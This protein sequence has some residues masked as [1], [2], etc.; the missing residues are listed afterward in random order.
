MGGGAQR[1][2]AQDEA[3]TLDGTRGLA[4]TGPPEG[5]ASTPSSANAAARTELLTPTASTSSASERAAARRDE[6]PALVVVDPLTRDAPRA[7]GRVIDSSGLPVADAELFV[8]PSGRSAERIAAAEV[9]AARQP[10]D[11]L[12]GRSGSDGR[13]DLAP[14]AAARSRGA[15]AAPRRLVFVALAPGFAPY[16]Y[17]LP[18]GL[19]DADLGEH[20]LLAGAVIAGRVLTSDG[21][22][23]ESA[24]LW[25]LDAQNR[26]ASVPNASSGE[27]L[28]RSEADGAF[29]FDSLAAGPWRVLVT[30]REHP[31]AVFTGAAAG[32]R[33]EPLQRDFVLAPGA[34]IEGSVRGD[35]AAFGALEVRVVPI[36]FEAVGHGPGVTTGTLRGAGARPVPIA[37][38]GTFVVRGLMAGVRYRVA[39]FERSDGATT[40]ARSE[41]VEVTSG[42]RAVTLT[43]LHETAVL[44]RLSDRASGASIERFEAFVLDGENSVRP[45]RVF[46][47]SPRASIDANDPREGGQPREGPAGPRAQAQGFEF[48]VW[49]A[50]AGRTLALVILG[51]GY[52]PL[53]RAGIRPSRG[54][55]LDLGELTLE[56]AVRLVVRV[57][58]EASGAPLAGVDVRLVGTGAGPE[59]GLV[60][61]VLVAARSGAAPW[62]VARTDADGRAELGGASGAGAEVELRG[63]AFAGGESRG[64]RVHTVTPGELQANEVVLR[65]VVG[66]R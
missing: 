52:A 35:R 13:F 58:D 32:T 41:A 16:E 11:V 30:S 62:L 37:P 21:I 15:W 59:A 36:Q 2:G 8:L 57:V 56:P 53:V 12:V 6:T 29:V 47:I 5:F 40:R 54:Q 44:F 46:E 28:G 61:A 33:A 31:D 65:V 27:L 23:V 42:A 49:P 51:P 66:A 9:I 10:D 60:R 1:G 22:P 43:L 45:V 63:A 50:E 25:R 64:P 55:R 34:V 18:A 38:D 4:P 17:T 48:A 3:T 39:A 7:R 19:V 24:E 20:T 14:P 26:A